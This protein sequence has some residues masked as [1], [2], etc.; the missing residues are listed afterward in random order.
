MDCVLA[1]IECE[2]KE[3]PKKCQRVEQE[4]MPANDMPASTKESPSTEE[5]QASAEEMPASTD[6]VPAYKSACSSTKESP[7]STKGKPAASREE[8]HAS[9]K[10]MPASTDEVPASEKEDMEMP[11]STKEMPGLLD[12]ISC[13]SQS[14]SISRT[15]S[16]GAGHHHVTTAAAG[17]HSPCRRTRSPFPV[18]VGS[19]LGGLAAGI[20]VDVIVASPSAGV[21]GDGAAAAATSILQTE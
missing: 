18:F 16:P 7:T 2:E 20:V 17:G 1:R 21:P 19:H 4:E 15:L 6:E 9:A 13:R 12:P 8:M 14:T 10:E 11:A 3:R 5:K